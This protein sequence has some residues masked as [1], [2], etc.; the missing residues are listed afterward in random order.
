MAEG[1][2][3]ALAI[4]PVV[5]TAWEGNGGLELFPEKRELLGELAQFDMADNPTTTPAS[6]RYDRIVAGNPNIAMNDAATLQGTGKAVAGGGMAAGATPTAGKG[7]SPVSESQSATPT[8]ASTMRSISS[9]ES[10]NEAK[11]LSVAAE[12]SEQIVNSGLEA[13]DSTFASASGVPTNQAPAEVTG[14]PSGEAEGPISPLEHQQSEQIATT[15]AQ[16]GESAKAEQTANPDPAQTA[17]DNRMIEKDRQV[18][19]KSTQ[20]F[21]I[22]EAAQKLERDIAITHAKMMNILKM[23][24]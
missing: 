16:D 11:A 17:Q 14:V 19:T 23:S 12:V 20:G 9:S 10:Q 6:V 15:P 24:V 5:N 13:K 4:A 2:I 18:D 22:F 1:L 8:P 21:R 7:Q 3:A